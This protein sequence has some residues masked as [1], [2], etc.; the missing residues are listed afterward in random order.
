MAR[1]REIDALLLLPPKGARSQPLLGEA[2]SNEVVVVPKASLQYTV[3]KSF[4]HSSARSAL[5]YGEVVERK[6]T[7]SKASSRIA[8]HDKWSQ[9]DVHFAKLARACVADPHII[10]TIESTGMASA[11]VREL[12]GVDAAQT[13][14]AVPTD[15]LPD[16]APALWAKDKRAGETPPDFIRRVYEPWI[17]K[18][19]VRPHI[20][21]LDIQLYVALTNWLR[22]NDMPD[23]L[24]LPTLKE[25]NDRLAAQ[26]EAGVRPS[27][28]ELSAREASRLNG[29]LQRR[30]STQRE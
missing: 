7:E 3:T 10:D 4:E 2:L 30:R 19:L 9:I 17:G 5:N 25:A 26:L 6:P 18:G 28:G 15:A 1:S 14:Q 29:V 20:K 11:F 13:Q 23:D 27:Y 16:V 12:L 24:N 21:R 8:D 22:K